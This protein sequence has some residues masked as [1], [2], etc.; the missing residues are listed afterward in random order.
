MVDRG[1]YLTL[2][3]SEDEKAML[4]ALAEVDGVS[5]SDVVRT[6]IRTRYRST[7]GDKPPKTKKPAK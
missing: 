7:F 6:F 5:A 2:R 4:H 3:I 1:L